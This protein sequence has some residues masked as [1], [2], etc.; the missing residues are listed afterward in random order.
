ML[1][2]YAPITKALGSNVDLNDYKTYGNFYTLYDSYANTI[3]NSPIKTKGFNLQV[4]PTKSGYVCQI[5]TARDGELFIRYST[6]SGWSDWKTITTES[7]LNTTLA[8]YQKRIVISDF[9]FNPTE[10]LP[11]E[12]SGSFSFSTTQ[13]PAH[14]PTTQNYFY[15]DVYHQS[16]TNYYLVIGYDFLGTQFKRRYDT[17]TESWTSL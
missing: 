16:Y 4:V 7:D 12:K 2:N 9:N 3:L 6:S 8:E 1:G 13:A 10:T 11:R 5:V 17:S 15:G 14:R